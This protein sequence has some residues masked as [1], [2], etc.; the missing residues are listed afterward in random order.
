M[1]A[2]DDWSVFWHPVNSSFLG[3]DYA[4]R[5]RTAT[6]WTPHLPNSEMP[7]GTTSVEFQL[8]CGGCVDAEAT[9]VSV[10][11]PDPLWSLRI[12][13][14]GVTTDAV[15]AARSLAI[16]ATNE[17]AHRIAALLGAPEIGP[18]AVSGNETEQPLDVDFPGAIAG[19]QRTNGIIRLVA[20]Q[21]GPLFAD[22]DAYFSIGLDVRPGDRRG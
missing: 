8:P 12:E 18:V 22:E 14:A 13:A 21:Y 20:G 2:I 4:E 6:G 3:R 15:D 10:K 16:A 1:A 9:V 17:Y 5:V 19:W 7:N 11:R